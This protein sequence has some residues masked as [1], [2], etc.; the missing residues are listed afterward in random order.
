ME[1]FKQVDTYKKIDDTFPI[2]CIAHN[3]AIILYTPGYILR[4]NHIS[5]F[6]ADDMEDNRFFSEILKNEPNGQFFLDKAKENINKWES[7]RQVPFSVDCLTI[8]SGNECN[9]ACKYCY[10]HD[11]R[12]GNLDLVG[13]PD[14]T[15]IEILFKRMIKLAK[16][17]SGRI[18]VV[19]HGSGEPTFHWEK[20]VKCHESI[21][22]VAERHGLRIISY[23]A[24]NGCL[25]SFQVEWL[26]KKMTLIGISCDGNPELQNAQR[27]PN[28]ICQLTIPDICDRILTLG[29]HFDIRVTITPETISRQ[30]EIV[31]YLISECHATN[32]RVEPVYH[33]KNN[34]FLAKDAD[35]FLQH[36]NA[37]KNY[38]ALYGAF[39]TYS[40][41]RISELHGTY[42]DVLRNNLRLT[43]DGFTRNCFCFMHDKPMYITGKLECGKILSVE[44]R[45]LRDLKNRAMLIPDKCKDCINMLH[46]SRGCPDY[47]IYYE[48]TPK[49][50]RFNEF[51]CRLHQLMTLDTIRQWADKTD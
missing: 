47:C 11:E 2:F 51:R 41:V 34:A 46:C 6:S 45:H 42:C 15:A 13:F 33:A 7:T 44:E 40:G 35:I 26:A 19:Y 29:G 49:G 27:K 10:A 8:H 24:T 21:L 9:R 17:N 1:T 31:K 50:G 18:S 23:L 25:T 48:N 39:F 4:L 28:R 30:T 36:F 20:L 32:I 14:L 38:A 37:A 43:S 3:R 5:G 12:T 16:N 22:K